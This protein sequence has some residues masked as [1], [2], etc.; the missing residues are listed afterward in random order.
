LL[1]S[2]RSPTTGVTDA[3]AD[4]LDRCVE[5]SFRHQ[6]T[7][8]APAE[9]VAEV[10]LDLEHYPEWWP[11][12]LAVAKVD[13]DTA[14][15]LCRSRLPYTL[16]LVL[17]ARDRGPSHLRVDLEGDLLGWSTFDLIP[18]GG[19]TRVAYRQQVALA[20]PWLGRLA[21]IGGPVLRWN[22]AQMM[23]GCRAG[24]ARRTQA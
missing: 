14:R 4:W 2:A 13:D 6:W 10:L 11:Q 18:T 19:G 22:H 16:D 3:G 24:L 9:R 8:D 21:G 7:V 20:S 17:C 12:V 15:V 5:F 23:A 1:R